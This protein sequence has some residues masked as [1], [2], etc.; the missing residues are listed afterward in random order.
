MIRKTCRKL[1]LTIFF[2]FLL[3]TILTHRSYNSTENAYVCITLILFTFLYEQGFKGQIILMISLSISPE[4][5][6]ITKENFI[7]NFTDSLEI[8]L[9]FVFF[10]KMLLI[11]EEERKSNIFQKGSDRKNFP[12]FKF[13]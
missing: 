1:N 12:P 7:K 4:L 9:E 10:N 3:L 5:N 13:K 11:F 6:K 8:L 2:F